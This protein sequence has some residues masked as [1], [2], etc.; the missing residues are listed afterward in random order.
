MSDSRTTLASA[1][2]CVLATAPIENAAAAVYATA[3]QAQRELFPDASAFE[4]VAVNLSAAQL[5]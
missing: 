3:E 1:L 4:A 5:Q 2:V